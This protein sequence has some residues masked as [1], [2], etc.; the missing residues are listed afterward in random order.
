MRAHVVGGHRLLEP[1]DIERFEMPR[2]T[3]RL[4]QGE[5]LIGVGHDVPVRAD[6][7]AYRAEAGDILGDVRP[8]AR[9]EVAR[10]RTAVPSRTP[11][12]ARVPRSLRGHDRWAGAPE[13]RR[14]ARR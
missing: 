2:A 12:R 5:A 8:A 9:A 3:D 7:T 13:D 11:D 1:R 14:A 4:G 6:R 10:R